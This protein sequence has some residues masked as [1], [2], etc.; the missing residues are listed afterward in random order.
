MVDLH[1]TEKEYD[2]NMKPWPTGTSTS[3]LNMHLGHHKIP[4]AR[5]HKDL[6]SEEGKKLESIKSDIKM[7]RLK[8]LNYGLKNG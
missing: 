3:P 6:K 1:L 2:G 8:H 4:Y 5:H 7:A